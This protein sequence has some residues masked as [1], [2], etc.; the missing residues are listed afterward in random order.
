MWR[1]LMMGLKSKDKDDKLKPK[2]LIHTHRKNILGNASLFIYVFIFMIPHFN[3]SSSYW[4]R[5]P[6]VT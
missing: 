2:S 3:Q 6:A 5:W 1:I 4:T